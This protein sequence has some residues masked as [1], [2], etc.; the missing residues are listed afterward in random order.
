MF[1]ALSPGFFAGSACADAKPDPSVLENSAGDFDAQIEA[2]VERWFELLEDPNAEARG[3]TALLS[4]AP[5]ELLLEGEALHDRGAL[6]AWLSRFRAAYSQ[7]E[8]RLDPIRIQAEGRDRY[9]IHF[10]FDRHAFDQSGLLHLARREHSWIVRDDS[11]AVPV[12]LS[13]EERPLLFFPGTGPQIVC[14]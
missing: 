11:S 13:I 7:I 1:V 14:Y 12:I 2:L 3:L 5:F 4:E 9:R 10:E 8:H 6:I